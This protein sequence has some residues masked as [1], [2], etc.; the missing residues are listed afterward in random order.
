MKNKRC[1]MSRRTFVG[2]GLSLAAI[3]PMARAT[4]GRGLVPAGEGCV[5]MAEQE[6]GPYYVA[7]ELLRSDIS[8][9][10][11]GLPLELRIQILQVGSCLP[12]AGAA[13]DIWHCDA[14]GV[15][16][17]FTAMG[18]GVAPGGPRNGGPPPGGPPPSFGP[19]G[20]GPS[21]GPGPDFRSHPTDQLTFLRGIQLSDATG[22]VDFRTV[23]PGFYMG[24]TNHIHLKVRLGGQAS[25]KSYEA[26]HTSHTG[27]IFFPEEL[28]A[29]LMEQEPYSRHKIHRLTQHEDHVFGDQHG[30][31]AIASVRW[32]NP[33]KFSD[34]LKAEFVVAVDPQATPAKAGFGGGPGR[35][36]GQPRD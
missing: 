3:L 8:E 4:R 5:L 24:R 33:V 14:L 12:L 17:G 2:S 11:A 36:P 28:A 30:E 13:V 1:G 6:E 34:G 15:Y 9:G 21:G 20:P 23:F 7:G 27:Q 35:P 26:G 31:M 25:G 29:K 10:K 32:I 16:S 22:S 19:G 18:G